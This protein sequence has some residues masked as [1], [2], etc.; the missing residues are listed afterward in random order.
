MTANNYPWNAAADPRT[1]DPW[2]AEDMNLSSTCATG[3][4]APRTSAHLAAIQAAYGSGH[5]FLG[6]LE[7][8]IIDMRPYLEPVLNMHH[9]QQSFATRQ[10]MIDAQGHARNQVIWFAECS[11]T[12]PVTLSASCAFDPTGLAF[13]TLDQWI[14]NIRA[15][16][17]RGVA[18]N[19]PAAAI[20]SCFAGDGTLIHAGP[21]SWDGI[22]DGRPAGPC[23]LKFP[24]HSTSRIE[25]G[26][27][28][29]GDVFKCQ[30]K[31]VDAALADGTYGSQ[32][33]ST[34][35]AG[36]LKEIFPGGVC[37]W[38]KPDAGRPWWLGHHR[39]HGGDDEA[40][41]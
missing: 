6:R 8:P 17:H 13:D 22:L 1:F 23:T 40:R 31:P 26:G 25:A 21:D 20:D 15:H 29:R 36:R 28:I 16:P 12:N 27:S 33:F 39:H 10:R 41:D 4:P 30:L 18:R 11:D 9:A 24:L 5:V 3:A 38:S 34:A 35:E 7:L 37:D 32:V 2:S 14:A 19:R